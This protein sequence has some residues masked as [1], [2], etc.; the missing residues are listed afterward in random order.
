MVIKCIEWHISLIFMDE[1]MNATRV[2]GLFI[3]STF[4]DF[5]AEKKALR[6]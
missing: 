2:F 3:S 1:F 6:N 4:S 5:I